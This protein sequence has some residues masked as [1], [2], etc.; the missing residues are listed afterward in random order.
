MKFPVPIGFD[1]SLEV[2][3]A[4]CDGLTCTCG[5]A[6]SA[7]VSFHVPSLGHRPDCAYDKARA[8]WGVGPSG[9]Y[10][11]VRERFAEERREREEVDRG[12]RGAS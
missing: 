3:F 9:L 1:E 2:Y 4:R 11:R 12:G 8:V 6:S 10:D 7:S 5:T